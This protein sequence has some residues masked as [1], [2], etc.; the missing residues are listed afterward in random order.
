MITTTSSPD[1][2]PSPEEIYQALLRSL[3]RR[4]GFGITFIQCSPAA[5]RRLIQRV[6]QELPQKNIESLKLTE[7]IDNFYEIVANIANV[8]DINILF[9][10]GI[11]NS[12]KNY[13]KPGYGGDGD[14]YNLDTVPVILSHLNQQRE[15]FRD[16]FS[17]INFVFIL[18]VFAIKY[19]SRRAPDFFDWSSGVFQFPTESDLIEREASKLLLEGSY[20]K[21]CDLSSEERNQKLLTLQELIREP[22]KSPE[23]KV[24]LLVEQGN[25]LASARNY[26]YAI[27]SYEEAIEIEPDNYIA[28]YNRGYALNK[29]G[30]HEEAVASYNKAI[31]LKPDFSLAWQDRGDVLIDLGRDREAIASYE[32]AVF[33]SEFEMLLDPANSGFY[34]L[35]FVDRL[36]LQFNLSNIIEAHDILN[37]IYLRGY[38]KILSGSSFQNIHAWIKDAVYNL[39]IELLKITKKYDDNFYDNIQYLDRGRMIDVDPA[40]VAE[41]E[42]DMELLKE[43]LEKLELMDA[44]I[45][46]LRFIEGLSQMEIAKRLGGLSQST[47]SRRIQRALRKV[48]HSTSTQPPKSS[49][50]AN[51]LNAADG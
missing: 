28:W 30:R 45:I 31:K 18:P 25:L 22:N 23:L 29:L 39:L 50:R 42:S 33:D 46:R 12:L 8:D 20:Q 15:N 27:A 9:V 16:D 44:N 41:E 19:F 26:E 7:P 34:I 1:S 24:K 21:Y 47:V 49:A 36:L 6:K 14:Y 48:F 10:R 37:E 5:A 32:K 3:R 11:E 51:K 43:S 38:K 13:I 4:K 2:P 17:N 35:P 40:I